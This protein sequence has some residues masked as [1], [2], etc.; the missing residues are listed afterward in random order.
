MKKMNMLNSC[1]ITRNTIYKTCTSNQ[2]V[3]SSSLCPSQSKDLPFRLCFLLLLEIGTDMT[4]PAEVINDWPITP[5]IYNIIIIPHFWPCILKLSS[6]W[7]YFQINPAFFHQGRKL[8]NLFVANSLL[9]FKLQSIFKLNSLC[10]ESKTS[11]SLKLG[12]ILSNRHVSLLK[13]KEFNFFLATHIFKKILLKELH[14]EQ[15]PS[16]FI[17]PELIINKH[18]SW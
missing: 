17:A 8:A 12:G 6:I 15:N 3:N 2:T 4:M 1:Q 14:L 11:Q 13:L 7:L 5:A 18:D 9:N 10:S 16:D